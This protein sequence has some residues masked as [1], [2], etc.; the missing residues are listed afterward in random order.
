MEL[1]PGS[2]GLGFL[3][4]VL[5]ILSPCVLPLVPIVVGTALAAHPLGTLALSLGLALSF[6]GVGLF[7]ATIGFAIGLDAEWFRNIA[8][9]LLVGFGVILLSASLQ[10]RFAGA[11]TALGTYGDQ[12][13]R[14]LRIEGL[15]GQLVVGLLLGLVWAPCVG[16]TLGA[17]ATLASQGQ[18]LSQVALVMAVFGIG[19]ALPIAVIGSASRRLFTNSRGTLL[20]IGVYGKYLLGGLMVLLGLAILVGWDRSLEAYL[21]EIS[22]DWLTEL[23]TRF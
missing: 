14:R 20:R 12:W 8:A 10:Q 9:V 17:A 15:G 6:T 11:T 23:T 13:L 2:Y 5:S 22:P 7:V 16:P 4:G 18:T 21:V 19:A 1:G 3:A